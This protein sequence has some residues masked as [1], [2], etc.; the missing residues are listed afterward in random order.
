MIEAIFLF[1]WTI[2][3]VPF[4]LLAWVKITR[5]YKVYL[6]MLLNF[7]YLTGVFLLFPKIENILGSIYEYFA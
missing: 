4:V 6:L 1:S 3:F 5:H 7:I 2:L